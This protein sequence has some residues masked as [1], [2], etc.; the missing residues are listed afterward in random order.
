[1][2]TDSRLSRMLHVLL[3]MARD[4]QPVTSER[5]AQMLGTNPAVV[6]RTMGGLREAGYVRS[7]KGHGGGWTLD[8]DLAQVTLLDVY[9]AVGSERL[10][11]MGF[12]NVHPDCLVEK[13]VNDALQDAMEQATAI[14]LERLGAVSLADLAERFTML[15]P[16]DH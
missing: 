11:A 10:F 5:I 9:R 3:H 16:K 8:C 12:D 2:R 14:L 6:R 1:M 13:V 4:D 7:E 15:Y